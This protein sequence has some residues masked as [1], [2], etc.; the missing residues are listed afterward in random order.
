MSKAFLFGHTGSINRGCEAIVRSTT[1]L[2]N[3]AGI[4][5]IYL[6]SSEE[7]YDK[8]LGV[9]KL[10]YYLPSKKLQKYS[11]SRICFGILKRLFGISAPIEKSRLKNVLNILEKDDVVLI[12]GGDTYCYGKPKHL[13]AANKIFKKRGAKTILWSCSIEKK[14]LDKEMINDLNRY[15]YIMP[16]EKITFETLKNC[17]ISSDKIIQMSDSAFN[18]NVKDCEIG[19]NI[20]NTVGINISPIV[21]KNPTAY[22]S[23]V[24]LIRYII[25]DTDMNV[26]LIP[27]VYDKDIEDDKILHKLY[28][29][30]SDKDKINIVD[31][32]YNCEEIK[33]I[34][35][36]CR[37]F[38]GART[39]ATIAAYSSCVP[40]LVLGY[41]VKSRG[42]ACDLFGTDKGYA[43]MYDTV[44]DPDALKN[45]FI[46]IIRDEENIK[47]RLI[48]YIPK[49]KQLGQAAAEKIAKLGN[50]DKHHILYH[51]DETCSGCGLCA[52]VCPQKCISMQTD[53][54]GFRYPKTDFAKCTECGLCSSKCSAANP[55]KNNVAKKFFAAFT[56]DD[57]LRAQSSSGGVFGTLAQEIL[58]AGG[59]VFGA[60][61][62]DN[63]NVVHK[64]VSHI[65]DLHRLY[66]SKYVQSNIENCF[67][68]VQDKLSNGVKV[69]FAGTPC[70]I[71]ALKNYIRDDLENLV[72]VDFICHGVPSPTAWKSY[73]Q[74]RSAHSEIIK[75]NFRSKVSGWKRFSMELNFKDKSSWI[76]NTSEDSYLK[77]FLS[78]ISVRDS[79]TSCAYKGEIRASDITLADFWG[80]EQ[81]SIYPDF[82][83]DKGTSLVILNSKSGNELFNQISANIK[84]LEVSKCDALKCN[85]PYY[86]SVV[87]NGLKKDFFRDLKKMDFDKVVKKYCGSSIAAKIRRRIKK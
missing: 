65:D 12:I 86:E 75:A 16:R 53:D 83:D 33:Y 63:M 13:Y 87:A 40:T 37:F 62:D 14:L 31:G 70:Q 58:S 46:D 47:E 9:D 81:T 17:G 54:K 48:D 68:E 51:N 49:Y 66:G 22:K 28:G 24:N 6:V 76:K 80:I 73:L 26:L 21:V 15:D 25:D 85:K 35:S 8:K 74:K 18:L 1:T 71:G 10:C 56:T 41:S 55:P 69:L 42:I 27:H 50:W 59:V 3:D 77:A 7:K 4:N 2:L 84:S 39:H 82:A 19:V 67:A 44:N 79:C 64:C 34:I 78:D 5:D 36:K 57:K 52:A 45:A 43:L 29:E 61:F 11:P 30:F 32:F 72:T 38:V 23:A 60:A 20:Q